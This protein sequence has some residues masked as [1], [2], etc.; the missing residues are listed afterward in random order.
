MVSG[1]E[2][3]DWSNKFSCEEDGLYLAGY[4]CPPDAAR[5]VLF[6]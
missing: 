3:Y 6:N 2:R 5:Q 4:L 1:I